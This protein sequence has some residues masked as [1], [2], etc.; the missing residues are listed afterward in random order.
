MGNYKFQQ[1][2]EYEAFCESKK[3]KKQIKENNEVAID[4]PFWDDAVESV[5]E[6]IHGVAGDPVS[7]DALIEYLRTK[8]LVINRNDVAGP[9]NMVLAHILD[10]LFQSY[11]QT[12]LGGDTGCLTY[13]TVEAG[14]KSLVISQLAN[15]ILHK[16]RTEAG[17]EIVPGPEVPEPVA[18]V[19][20]DCGC[21]CMPFESRRV[22]GFRH[23]CSLLK[24]SLA[25]IKCEEDGECMD[26]ILDTL[27]SDFDGLNLDKIQKAAE[28]K[29]TTV[30]G[31]ITGMVEDYLESEDVELN[32]E[33]LKDRAA[34][35]VVLRQA[36]KL[37]AFQ[38]TRDI[39]DIINKE[40]WKKK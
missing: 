5:M 1:I 25:R 15:E 17:L 38:T 27:Q 3:Q 13:D 10:L 36:R 21:E 12:I 31:Y 37:F 22:A 39:M 7:W 40:N 14:A 33:M 28:K 34:E 6:D 16:V 26:F 29:N 8:F 30:E 2:E 20:L 32:G 4:V 23:F 9:E 11:G 35:S 18:K 24:E 19:S